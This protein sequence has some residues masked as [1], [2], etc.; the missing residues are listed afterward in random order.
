M[1]DQALG[2]TLLRLDAIEIGA[3]PEL[4]RLPLQHRHEVRMGVSEQGD[5][6]AAAEVEVAAPG[7]IEQ[8]GTLAAF[9]RD[10]G[11][12]VDR[13]ERRHGSIGHGGWSQMGVKGAPSLDRPGLSTT[14]PAAR[15]GCASGCEHTR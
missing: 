4:L 6:D 14:C 15:H 7:A 1:G 3:V 13:Q 5:R 11:P 9:E 2:Q 10:L 12:F 8:V